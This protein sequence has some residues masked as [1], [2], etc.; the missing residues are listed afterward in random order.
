[1]YADI[2]HPINSACRETIQT[3]V[4]AEYQGELER[5]KEPGYVPHSFPD[6]DYDEPPEETGQPEA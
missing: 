2:A 6:L 4:I 5:A 3:R 1:M